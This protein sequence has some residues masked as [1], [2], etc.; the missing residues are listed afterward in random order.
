MTSALDFL[1][2]L[3]FPGM[4]YVPYHEYIRSKKW[5]RKSRAFR[6]KHPKCDVC[7]KRATQVHHKS[8]RWIGRE[9]D[10]DLQA[11]CATCHRRHH[12]Y[13]K[14]RPKSD[15]PGAATRRTVK[16]GRRLEGRI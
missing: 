13:L 2:R 15:V 14:W 3:F 5:R 10:R 7:G 1:N 11:L 16:Y 9:P 12:T 4:K 8:Y 6:E